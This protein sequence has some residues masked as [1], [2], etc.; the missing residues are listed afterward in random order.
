VAK[1]HLHLVEL[2]QHGPHRRF[3][4]VDVDVPAGEQRRGGEDL[5]CPAMGVDRRDE[6]R[7]PAERGQLWDATG[8][9]PLEA[10]GQG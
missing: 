8:E 10:A 5:R 3:E 7:V 9:G 2:Q 6:Q 4:H 1:L